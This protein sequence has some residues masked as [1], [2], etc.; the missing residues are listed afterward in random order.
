MSNTP[1]LDSPGSQKISP[2]SADDEPTQP[3]EQEVLEEQGAAVEKQFRD[4]VDAVF[5]RLDQDKSGLVNAHELKQF[6]KAE[7]NEQSLQRRKTAADLL[8]YFDENNDG[9]I[10]LDEFRRGM[11]KIRYEE[12]GFFFERFLKLDIM[13]KATVGSADLLFSPRP[14]GSARKK[15]SLGVGSSDAAAGGGSA[16]T[17]SSPAHDNRVAATTP[18]KKSSSNTSFATTD[19]SPQLAFRAG[20]GRSNFRK[21]KLLG[22]GGIGKVYLVQCI[23]VPDVQGMLFAMKVVKKASL[24][25]RNKTRR[26]LMERNFMATANHPFTC[27]LYATFQT[28]R[29][30]YFITQYCGGGEFFRLL[31]KQQDRRLPEAVAKFYA[32]EIL[33]ALEYIHCLGYLYR[34][35]KPENILVHES[36]HV[37]LTDFDFSKQ[38]TAEAPLVSGKQGAKGFRI[39]TDSR[40]NAKLAMSFVGTAEYM[41]PEMLHQRGYGAGV[42]WWQFGIL[43]YEMLFA[44]TPFKSKTGGSQATFQNIMNTKDV[45]IPKTPEISK[46][47]V[48]LLKRLLNVNSTKRLSN[49]AQIRR[50][51]WFKGIHFALI[52]SQTPPLVPDIK[53]PDDTSQFSSYKDELW[54]HTEDE[55][56]EPNGSFDL[57]LE[58][59]RLACDATTTA[60]FG[61][62]THKR[63][64]AK[65]V[66]DE[67]LPPLSAELKERVAEAKRLWGSF[68]Y[69]AASAVD[70]HWIGSTPSTPVATP[71]MSRM[72]RKSNLEDVDEVD[73][74]AT[75]SEAASPISMVETHA[76]GSSKSPAEV[77]LD[78]KVNNSTPVSHDEANSATTE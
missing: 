35:L 56:D 17:H 71:R 75:A 2:N 51:P 74:S 11:D 46:E 42:D 60:S 63:E 32:A 25:H 58:V 40:I 67:D 61:T 54:S 5:A 14:K 18:E 53:A 68:D 66:A 3:Q 13:F 43:L 70:P 64:K 76:G 78:D 41:P 8:K 49:A 48:D 59:R 27:S 10:D 7:N 45:K 24:I 72:S 33:L 50:H 73:L 15:L 21:L 22:Y 77:V 52:R 57:E 9:S 65:V 19:L 16:S 62:E 1:P 37:M 47:A 20:L 6:F 34:D 55:A 23:G 69:N 26:I 39:D 44:A 29:K 31:Q 36:G 30:L 4:S 38:Q 12:D 28:N